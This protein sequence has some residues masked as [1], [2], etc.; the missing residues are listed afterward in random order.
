MEETKAELEMETAARVHHPLATPLMPFHP[1][2]ALPLGRPQRDPVPAGVLAL[3][4]LSKPQ[5][6]IT[7]R[8]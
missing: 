7:G 2:D 6:H 8:P 5:S 4:A 1:A 3:D